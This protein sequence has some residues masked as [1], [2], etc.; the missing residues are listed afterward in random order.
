ML[1]HPLSLVASM[2]FVLYRGLCVAARQLDRIRVSHIHAASIVGILPHERI[3]PQ[4]LHIDIDL[5]V[6]VRPASM[7]ESCALTVD[8][9]AVAAQAPILARS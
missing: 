3:D 7:T 4:P 6:N 8:Y 2:R 5:G 1:Q 9:A